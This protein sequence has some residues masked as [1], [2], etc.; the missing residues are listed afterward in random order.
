MTTV[1]D[2]QTG[3]WYEDRGGQ[4]VPV[5]GPSGFAPSAPSP[6][7]F[8]YTMP[9]DLP[10]QPMGGGISGLLGA[11]TAGPSASQPA[12][13]QASYTATNPQTGERFRLVNGAWAP[14]QV[15]GADYRHAA[16]AGLGGLVEGAGSVAGWLGADETK[17]SL[18]Q[19]GRQT[20]EEAEGAMSPAAR[21][22]AGKEFVV[23]DPESFT[24]YSFGPGW[25]LSTI[26]LHAA[27]SAA[28]TLGGMAVGLATTAALP[29]A[30]VLGLGSSAASLAARIGLG[31]VAAMGATEAGVKTLGASIAGAMLNG[32]AE[33]LV[34]AGMGAADVE[35]FVL[36]AD[37]AVL[38]RSP[39]YQQALKENGG[40][41]AAARQKVA[42]DLA[43]DAALRTGITTGL[44]GA[45]AGAFYG[46]LTRGVESRG[47]A[48]A[49]GGGVIQEA[50]QEAPQSG[51]EELWQNLAK[52]QVDPTITPGQN[53]L[54]AAVGGAV[55]GGMMGGA[56]GGAGHTIGRLRH[57]GAA[58]DG[59]ENPIEGAA[60]AGGIADL[61][62]LPSPAMVS[63]TSDGTGAASGVPMDR[64]SRLRARELGKVAGELDK[65]RLKAEKAT[66]PAERDAAVAEWTGKR[67]EYAELLRRHQ[68]AMQ[69][70]P[71]SDIMESTAPNYVPGTMDLGATSSTGMEE[72]PA[73]SGAAEEP[74]RSSSLTLGEGFVTGDGPEVRALRDLH[75]RTT[76]AAADL[77]K[78]RA[79]VESETDPAKRAKLVEQWRAK[80]EALTA[81]TAQR[82][83]LL[84]PPGIR[85]EQ[86]PPMPFGPASPTEARTPFR[87]SAAEE[88]PLPFYGYLADWVQ[89]NGGATIAAL[90][91]IGLSQPQAVTAMRRLRA[92]GVV[93]DAGAAVPRAVQLD[94]QPASQEGSQTEGAGEPEVLEDYADAAPVEATAPTP[95]QSHS[96]GYTMLDPDQIG[97]DAGR[98]QF[99]AG[100]DEQGVT[101]R[102]RGVRKWNPDLA[103]PIMAWQDTGGKLW[104]ADGHQRTGLAKRAKDAGQDNVQVP[105]R[106]YREEDGYSAE[107]MRYLAAYRNI[108]EGTGSPVDAAKIFRA[109]EESTERAG[110]SAPELPPSS[111]LVRDGKA[112]AKLSDDAFG[113]VVNDIV[114]PDY[115]AHVGS[116]IAD[117]QQQ[118][119]ALDVLAK[120]QPSN[121][122]QA[123]MIVEDVRNAG[124]DTMSQGSLFGEEQVTESLFA[125]RAKV[126]DS[127][128]REIRGNRGLFK[129][130]ISGESALTEAG[131]QLDTEA[132]QQRLKTDEQLLALLEANATRRGPVSDALTEAAR[133]VRGGA[134]V[135]TAAQRFIG[136]A[137]RID[138]GEA[139][140]VDARGVGAGRDG[141]APDGEPQGAQARDVTP[142]QG[143]LF[144]SPV[145]SA[146][147]VRTPPVERTAQGDQYQLIGQASTAPGKS[148][149]KVP[150]REA[151]EGLFSAPAAEAQDDRQL[152]I[153]AAAQQVSQPASKTDI[154]AALRVGDVF[155]HQGRRY[156][157]ES[158]PDGGK[159]AVRAMDVSGAQP[160]ARSWPTRGA[161]EKITGRTLAQPADAAKP[162]PTTPAAAPAAQATPLNDDF[163]NYRLPSGSRLVSQG[164]RA[165]A[166]SPVYDDGTTFK[167]AMSLTRQRAWLVDE[168][169]K[170]AA[171][172]GDSFM[173]DTFARMQPDN[174]SRS[175]FDT[176]NDYLF[177]ET[178]GP[179]EGSFAGAGQAA[180]ADR[181]AR[182]A[183]REEE[184]AAAKERA[185][186]ADDAFAA[187]NARMQDELGNAKALLNE[188][189]AQRR[190]LDIYDL[191]ENA[192]PIGVAKN[193]LKKWVNG[194]SDEEYRRLAEQ[195]GANTG[196]FKFPANTA[197]TMEPERLRAEWDGFL[198]TGRA[199]RPEASETAAPASYGD[200]NTVFTADAA[201]KARELLRRKLNGSQ[202]NSGIDP[203]VMQAGITLAGYH[204]EAGARSF[205]AYSKAMV[206]D[207]GE[208]VRPYLRSWYEALRYDPRAGHLSP[209]MTPAAEIDRLGEKA[210]EEAGASATEGLNGTE[211][212]RTSQERN[213]AENPDGNESGQQDVRGVGPAGVEGP[214]RGLADGQPGREAAAGE[215]EGAPA[216]DAGG[217]AP[218]R[219]G[220]GTGAR[221]PQPRGEGGPRASEG[222]DGTDGRSGA[223]REGVADAGAGEAGRRGGVGQSFA[224]QEQVDAAGLALVSGGD[225]K[226][227]VRL[228]DY[229]YATTVL[230]QESDA[231]W[232]AS[233]RGT[234]AAPTGSL[235]E[236]LAWAKQAMQAAAKRDRAAPAAE[237][238]QPAP[239]R[240]NY[241]V[242]DPETLIGGTP[243]VRFTR[244]RAAIE[245]YRSIT[246]EGRDPTAADLDAMAGY[247]GWGSFGQ[248]LFQGTWATP[249]PK[250]GWE[251]EDQWLREHLG[252]DEW[253]SA[254]RSII[255]A[256]YTDPPTVQAMWSMVE[257][258]GF[259]GGRVLE[260]SMGIGNFYGLMPRAL[261]GA[262]DLTGIELDKLTGGMAK[263]L[264]PQA[265][266]QI[267]GY[268]E[269]KTPDHFY[270]LVIGNWP[271][272]SEGPADRRYDKLNL[273][274]H[275]YFFVKAVDQVRPGGLVVGLT[276]SFTMDKIGRTARLHLARN[277]ELVAA[278]RMPSGAFEKYAGTKVVTDII[279]LKKRAA[280]LTSVEGEGWVNTVK[281]DVGNGNEITVN[282]YWQDHPE[283]VLG[284]MAFG[285]GTTWGREGMIV[286]RQEDFPQRLA[287]LPGRL[288]EGAYQPVKRGDEPRFISNN[289]ADREGAIT[290]GE[291]SGLYVVQGD[292]L[293]ALEDVVKYV[294]KDAKKTAAREAQIKALVGLRRA[295]GR[296]IDAE[297]D[298]AADTEERRADLRK[299]YQAFAKA[300]G[301]IGD[302]A[303]LE[304]LR[305]A[306]D[307]FYATL[308]ALETSDGKPAKILSEPTIR[309]KRKLA[310]PSVRDAFV[311]ARNE[312]TILDLGR[313]AE[314]AGRTEDE[315]AQDLLASKAIYRTPGGGYEVSDLFL[316]G[317]VRRKLREAEEAQERGEDMAASIEALRGV[318]PKDVPYFQVEAKLGATWVSNDDYRQFVGDLLGAGPESL[319]GIEV[320]FKAGQWKAVLKDRALRNRTETTTGFGTGWYNFDRLV[321]AAMNNRTIT[322]R[323]KDQDGND[324]VNDEATREVNEK[325]AKL[326]EEF[327]TWAWRDPE[328]RIRL[329]RGYNEV[330]N[331]IAKPS[332]D[333]SFL[334]FSGMA[335]RRGEDP[336]S[337]RSHQANAIWRG[338]ANGA[339]LYAHEVGTGKTL[340]MGGIAVESRRYGLARK[341]LILAHNANSAS[342]A[343][344]I[345]EMYPGAKILYVDN[346]SPDT[347][348]VTMRRIAND[349]W[350]AVV[351]P[352]SVIDRFALSEKTLMDLAAEEIAALE[353]EAMEAASDD[354]TKLTIAMMD[355]EEALKK[356][357]SPTAKQLVH[358]RNKI[359]QEIKKQATRASRD[360]AVTFE[361]LGIDMLIVDEAHEFKKPP[362]ATRMRMRGLN[363]ATSNRSIALRFMTDYIKRMRGGK[364]VHLFTG[365]PV[366]NTLTEIYNMMRYVMDGQMAQDGIKDW[367]AWFN[368]F[369][370]STNDVELTATGEYEP[371][372]RLAAFVNVA[373]LRRMIG[374]YMDIVFAD[375][376]PEF[377]PRKTADGKTLSSPDLTEAD[378]DALLNGRTENPI[379]R[380]YKKIVTDVGAMGPE[381][382]A[383]LD[384]LVGLARMFK[385]ATKKERKELMLSGHPSSP[386][387][388]ETNAANAGLDVRLFNRSAEDHPESKANRA[389]RNLLKHFQEHP[390]ATQVVF[391]ERGFTDTRTRTKTDRQGNKVRT[392]VE[393]FNLVNDM[394]EKLVAGGIPRDQIAIVDG[395]TSKEKRKQIADKMNRSEIRVVFGNTSTLGVGVNMQRNLRAMHHLDAPWMPGD[396][397][398]RNGRGHRQGNT[399]NTVLEY[400][401][402]TEKLDGRRWQVLSVKDRF[403]KAFLKADDNV[404]VIEG[405]AV[406]ADEG[407]SADDLAK[408]LAEAAGDPRILLRNK[409]QADIERLE[410]RERMH[411]FGIADA[412]DKV[413]E[414]Q[415][416][417]R[418]LA[419]MVEQARKD[420]DHVDAVRQAGGFSA[421]IGN[422]T[423]T[424]RKGVDDALATLVR[425][426]AKGETVTLG[427]VN[428]FELTADWSTSWWD[429]PDYTLSRELEY[430][431]KP[432]LASIEGVQRGIAKRGSE[433]A[434]RIAENEASIARLEA[435]AEQPFAQADTLA[436][437]M[438]MLA[439][440]ET[441]LQRNPVPPPSWLRFGAPVGTE[442]H[443]DGAARTVE[444]HKWTDDDWYVVTPEGDVPYLEARD[445]NGDRLYEPHPFEPPLRLDDQ[446][447]GQPASQTGDQPRREVIDTPDEGADEGAPRYRRADLIAAL[448]AKPDRA[449]ASV[450]RRHA[451][452]SGIPR[453]ELDQSGLIPWLEAR[454]GVVPKAEVLGFLEDVD[455]DVIHRIPTDDDHTSIQYGGGLRGLNRLA[456][457]YIARRATAMAQVKALVKRIAGDALDAE[458]A[459]LVLDPHGYGINGAYFDKLVYVSLEE[460]EDLPPEHIFGTVR[461]EIIH[462][463]RD[464]GVLTG[465]NWNALMRYAPE[466]RKAF[467][468]DQ[469]YAGDNLP[470][471][472]L[473]EEAVAEAYAA[474]AANRFT[475]DKLRPRGPAA[476]AMQR[477]R[478]FFEGMRDILH[479]LGFRTADSVFRSIESGR[480]AHDGRGEEG[481][482]MAPSFAREQDAGQEQ[483]AVNEQVEE[484]A[485]SNADFR[486][487]R[488]PRNPADAKYIMPD[489]RLL[490]SGDEEHEFIAGQLGYRSPEAFMKATGAVRVG[491]AAAMFDGGA[492]IS[493]ETQPTERQVARLASYLKAQ[494]G[495]PV[496]VSLG[497]A[498]ET[499]ENPTGAELSRA[500][501]R[502][503]GAPE[504]ARFSRKYIGPAGEEVIDFVQQVKGIKD[505]QVKHSL[506]PVENA[507]RVKADTGIDLTGFTRAIDNY[508]VNH[509]LGHHGNAKTEAARG[510]IAL[511][512]EDFGY[513]PLVLSD[514]DTV[515]HAG[516]N[517]IGRDVIRYTRRVNGVIAYVEEVRTGK[518]ETALQSMWK[519][520]ATPDAPAARP[521]PAQTSETFRSP[522]KDVGDSDGKVKYSRRGD[523][524][525]GLANDLG[526]GLAAAAK[527][528]G[529]AGKVLGAARRY[530]GGKG[531]SPSLPFTD[532]LGTFARIAVHPRMIAA[533][534]KQFVPVWESATGLMQE[535]DRY[536]MAMADLAAP[537]FAITPA[538][539]DKVNKVL[540][541]GRLMRQEFTG[542]TVAVTNDGSVRAGLSKAGETVRLTKEET[543][544]YK[545]VRSAMNRALDL[546]QVQ[547]LRSFGF[548]KPDDPYSS[549]DLMALAQ[550]AP[551][552][553]EKAQLEGLAE[554]IRGIENARR[555]GYIPF[556]R[557]GNIGLVVKGK[558]GKDGKRETVEYRL[559]ET[560]FGGKL[561][562]KLGRKMNADR[563]E[564]ARQELLKKYPASAGYEVTGPIEVTKIQGIIGDGVRL[565]DL[566]Q[567][568]SVAGADP[569]AYAM[570]REAL[571][572]AIKSNSFKAHFFQSKDVPGYSTD[573]ERVIADYIY[574]ISGYLARRDFE[575]KFE[576]AL[577]KIKVK[578]H[579]QDLYEYAL[580][581]KDYVMSPQEEWN[582]LRGLTFFYYLAG[583]IS[584][585]V[586]NTSQVP[587]VTVPYL[588]QFASMPKV[589][590]AIAAAY[591]DVRRMVS[592]DKSAGLTIDIGKA[593][594]KFRPALQSI[595]ADGLMAAQQTYDM[596]GLA[597][598][599]GVIPA[600]LSPLLQRKSRE[601]RRKA[602]AV[603]DVFTKV[604]S[605][606]ERLNRVVTALAT[607]RLAED[608][609]IARRMDS[610]LGGNPLYQA[611]VKTAASPQGLEA[612]ARW[613]IDETQ[614]RSG[615]VNRPTMMRGVGAPLM[616]FR[617][618][619]FQMLET[620]Y[621]MGVQNGGAGRKALAVYAGMMMLAAGMLGLP[622]GDDA[623]D[624]IEGVYRWANEKDLDVEQAVYDL[625]AQMGVPPIA[626]EIALRGITRTATGSDIGSRV[627][628]GDVIPNINEPGDIGMPFEM[629]LGRLGRATQFAKQGRDLEAAGELLPTFV[630]NPLLAYLWNEEGV[631]TRKGNVVIPRDEITADDVVLKSMGF[632]STDIA[633]RREQ[634]YAGDRAQRTM[635]EYRSN[636]MVRI[637][638]ERAAMIRA[639]QEGNAAAYRTAQGNHRSIIEEVQKHNSGAVQAERI[640]LGHP[641]TQ[642]AIKQ[643]VMQELQGADAR[644]AK[645]QARSRMDEIERSRPQ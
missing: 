270:D 288:P 532:R 548:G 522:S 71:R 282:Q 494:G 515:E 112:L 28:P 367:D 276:S 219:R 188:R 218:S 137:Q 251:K 545:A 299:Q 97:V 586:V 6:L 267:K 273:S 379:G 291:D 177:G 473:N 144:G 1:Y 303:G 158:I 556:T 625:V 145:P 264:Y 394:V 598:G 91:D 406:S 46:R 513:I 67:A 373:E 64:E 313:V 463:L 332:Y 437:K 26:G 363:T 621:R 10:A 210:G 458:V 244:N 398:Q 460:A 256:H 597:T 480:L 594:A 425:G 301:T 641:S 125:E 526:E 640:N 525:P 195:Y 115:A 536:T 213:A 546:F 201:E 365:T 400:R 127:A 563:V 391:L 155:E 150:Q 377:S 392:K 175:D 403:I 250:Q 132:N 214:G 140:A 111:T 645:R 263:L 542:D 271:F 149:A 346:L 43:N 73:L 328:R 209:E 529:A 543:A 116:L 154:Q 293:A 562:A 424:E 53:L 376:M 340:T 27:Q 368:T 496:G 168:A 242:A 179:T 106:I 441:D 134:S 534:H 14:D 151:D 99:K 221:S 410:N 86:G 461:H 386:V 197:D 164:G 467:N 397:E 35:R 235:D 285:R 82:D 338:I 128:L 252:K 490:G 572:H 37:E 600:A 5:Q 366:T 60:P 576:D 360:G 321:S 232:T 408:T 370:D 440:L 565:H 375:D 589:G 612:M 642:A 308:A 584:S 202:V 65:L 62:A 457:E 581:Y 30:M 430:R 29:E 49:I 102:L 92:D 129:K 262:S 518:R 305:R 601:F 509:T 310:E 502:M 11:R 415:G 388:V 380:P 405:D 103:S 42:T 165:L 579:Q 22:T 470:A 588:S 544:A 105:A 84:P 133:A 541:L 31:R 172:N 306:E 446:K 34:A 492:D 608:A 234:D 54:N 499:L 570:V 462:G 630:R 120:T 519:R 595:E 289:T 401:Y 19:W 493:M 25:N 560:D 624:L 337:L 520:A 333:G 56:T 324:V 466:W 456:P 384:E 231:V 141:S 371:V 631:R 142:D 449:P 387:I 68:A 233:A 393:G 483:G 407:E 512:D 603:A 549:E 118:V 101:D 139:P 364:G 319:G 599:Q 8:G 537:Y 552:D 286:E 215:L 609:T 196:G 454:R 577:E 83:A 80:N 417:N 531:S 222:R 432:S 225:R 378:R 611:E 412:K 359:I 438:A 206:G 501:A 639:E 224:H 171:A 191:P 383:A 184:R 514:P 41:P 138:A 55:V 208:A 495:R 578:E 443:V 381:Q 241:H 261:M 167:R 498:F 605:A 260:P 61:L 452:L 374:Q 315:V 50:A 277:A 335:L 423:F 433:F 362:L 521:S 200:T 554:K 309:T 148:K 638:R 296:L 311:L 295:Y 482:R 431:V 613:L 369:A 475:A 48:G 629:T 592:W 575:P 617:D 297:R 74:P 547:V 540:E 281:Q 342:V 193:D 94:G 614:F 87:F 205:A 503:Q 385:N 147:A 569:E 619:Q 178:S 4:M 57:S 327:S 32:S 396:L 491:I 634:I 255:N 623:K 119:A 199:F 637:A 484:R 421:T 341:P 226:F 395:G 559:V 292:R 573:F 160:V 527:A 130:A 211:N 272:A 591:N 268:E 13:P 489:G 416:R 121:S 453:E 93:N 135:R 124:F 317:N 469:R 152:D 593:P 183:V 123:R 358:Q 350:D 21:E 24:G 516:K 434:S 523:A 564:Q 52:G 644:K 156:R 426:L 274:L 429:E 418:S 487:F 442:I 257:R 478:R 571:D 283:N 254:Q 16:V 90:R 409:L 143:G 347:I 20:R 615:K 85:E 131:N 204:I 550:D 100:G 236:M 497:E 187:S 96:A 153:E 89:Q 583:N 633:R 505:R 51:L 448:E 439:D 223:G 436:K 39:V 538:Q 45:P 110:P 192:H 450:W 590:A 181:T 189:K 488:N 574:S 428:G 228:P 628:M 81:L 464:L 318:L 517:G 18:Q 357:R 353:E 435:M 217:P 411:T 220:R 76:T 108:A 348:A 269:S 553:R 607:M 399:W 587:L 294:V 636:L 117:P 316:S 238:E 622:F 551:G 344:E 604:F 114:P 479:R 626:A 240:S 78:I 279:V 331:A 227:T 170:E 44:L 349:D 17:R 474:W 69:Q 253:E 36:E 323:T 266:V 555:A 320:R 275:D 12:S 47:L 23:D 302:S 530:L 198:R 2:P 180:P 126:L 190:V 533:M 79:R 237:A 606:A 345:Q 390:Q 107:D 451:E 643:R 104:V 618:F 113:M 510:Q 186:A 558:P 561:G 616:Q 506:G 422:K 161:F 243:K 343:R 169:R 471:E 355:D 249:R 162:A 389:V 278:Y 455:P 159:G 307:P 312:S 352:H 280:P 476:A 212:E 528:H 239:L 38:D 3:N 632:T 246:E 459:D 247:I 88:E 203:E 157:M 596:M 404:R 402:I 33:G 314:M 413:R 216:A 472:A 230:R 300:H 122:A 75:K 444:G 500:L 414:L 284:R 98:F 304:I 508:G 568:A 95:V 445:V 207:L 524:G 336:F 245:A 185:R 582:G 468:I 372:S 40:D 77:D 334:E 290:V 329:E 339:G 511:T 330:M 635:Q 354:D 66:D 7:Q 248:E 59:E 163:G 72:Q 58:P 620:L 258:L 356:V 566:D 176:V 427:T 627:G 182:R 63:A 610:V 486:K 325:I 15:T 322:I 481:A 485:L 259:K 447:A 504:S 507:D 585:A 9:A 173:S 298:G 361:D 580:T 166:P 539:R 420:A 70:P 557:F 194:L 535:R 602:G 351:V 567:L 265:N 477:L 109:A 287:D 229:Q 136:A 174:F 419:P 465:A 326:R 382:K 146:P